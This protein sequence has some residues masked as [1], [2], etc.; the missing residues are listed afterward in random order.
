MIL[1]V[2]L[3]RHKVDTVFLGSV[4][5]NGF[6]TVCTMER[7]CNAFVLFFLCGPQEDRRAQLWKIKGI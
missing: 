3:H 2:I 5:F 4:N 6:C 7:L 1:P